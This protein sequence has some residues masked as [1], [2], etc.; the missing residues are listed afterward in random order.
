[1]AT[2]GLPKVTFVTGNAKKLEEVKA[3]LSTGG[4]LPFEVVSQKI[5]LPELQGEPEEI[6]AQK[7]V[8]AAKEVG[9]PVMVE[10]TS[11]CFNA[12]GGLPGPYIKWF[13]EKTGHTGLN[14]LLAAY[15]DKSAYAQCIFSYRLTLILTLTLT[16]TLT[17][18]AQCIF[19]YS[20]GPGHTPIVFDGRTPGRIVPARGPADQ[21][22]TKWPLGGATA[23]CPSHMSPALPALGCTVHSGRAAQL[24]RAQ[25]EEAADLRCGL[26]AWPKSTMLR[27]S[28]RRNPYPDPSPNPHTLT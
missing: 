19:S 2:A 8:L 28:T 10:D 12:L 24:P 22:V 7:C 26:Q 14:N 9:G 4:A 11:L 15:E 25:W 17:P 23:P 16:L 27:P 18:N 20:A 6:S 13:L 21:L 1:M 5:D 3:I